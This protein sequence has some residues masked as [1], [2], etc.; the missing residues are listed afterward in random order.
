EPRKTLTRLL[1]YVAHTHGATLIYTSTTD[2]STQSRLR[3]TLTHHA[4]RTAGLR[5]MQVDPT[6]PVLVPAGWDDLAH[7]G[8]PRGRETTTTGGEGVVGGGVKKAGAVY[9][10]WSVWESVAREMFPEVG[11]GDGDRG[12][13]NGRKVNVLGDAERFREESVDALRVQKDL[14]LEKLRRANA[15]RAAA[16]A[17]AAASTAATTTTAGKQRREKQKG[18]NPATSSAILA[19]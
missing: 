3:A 18:T 16:A 19:Q 10:Q 13:E 11:D 14:E 7:I 9:A 17:A 6:R 12:G 2:P 5:T 8:G 15:R 1:R 4:F